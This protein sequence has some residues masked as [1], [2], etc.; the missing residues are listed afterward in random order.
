[1]TVTTRWRDVESP[2]RIVYDV[3]WQSCPDVNEETGWLV[4]VHI[5][6]QDA[7]VTSDRG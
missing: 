6:P 7:M 4:R 3:W 1:M 5:Q 2:N